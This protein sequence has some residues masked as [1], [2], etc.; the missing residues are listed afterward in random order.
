MKKNFL[1]LLVI[2]LATGMT[3]GCSLFG[4]D[5][6]AVTTP[7][8]QQVNL[9]GNV[10]AA[11]VAVNAAP[12]RQ[13]FV[14][15]HE[16]VAVDADTGAVLGTSDIDALRNYNIAVSLAAARR[17]LIQVRLKAVPTRIIVKRFIGL[18]QVPTVPR[19]IQNIVVDSASTAR[20]IVA[21]AL[22][23]KTNKSAQETALLN[24]PINPDVVA[25]VAVNDPATAQVNS[26][27]TEAGV[28][29]NTVQTAIDTAIATNNT[30]TIATAVTT[31]TTA[32]TTTVQNATVVLPYISSIY[33]DNSQ[34][35]V[36][37]STGG[38][39]TQAATYPWSPITV[40]FSE[41]VNLSQAKIAIRVTE[42]ITSTG[43]VT[44]KVVKHGYTRATGELDWMTA[45]GTTPPN[46]T[47]V[48]S[49]T[50][51]PGDGQVRPGYTANGHVAA[52][53]RIDLLAFE[54]V[55]KAGGTA[56]LVAPNGTY[57]FYTIPAHTTQ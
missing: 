44:T 3:A 2:L 38:A 27:A 12:S 36:Y 34:K 32:T 41:A 5:D 24:T 17:T 21:V 53:I 47:S 28:N 14:P 29:L 33:V 23:A 31:Q 57:G 30:E 46:G 6:A 8:A 39:T 48:T 40:G 55:V 18:L 7:V 45:F 20:A 35:T 10:P 52:T 42:T 1:F 51:T 37:T 25:D 19:T 9:A 4:K 16:A 54:G 50:I 26:Y 13:G 22:I 56:A 43:A 15:I 49:F 11:V